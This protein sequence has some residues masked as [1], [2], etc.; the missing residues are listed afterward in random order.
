MASNFINP[1]YGKK[2]NGSLLFIIIAIIAVVGI[3]ICV[4]VINGSKPK[5]NAPEIKKDISVELGDEDYKNWNFYFSQID[6]KCYNE[7]N[8][9]VDYSKIDPTTVGTYDVDITIGSA[10]PKIVTV[11]LVDTK[12]PIL[13]L[14]S[15]LVIYADVTKEKNGISYKPEDFVEKCEDASGVCEVSFDVDTPEA[16]EEMSNHFEPG[17]YPISIVAHDKPTQKLPQGRQTMPQ[18]TKLVI[19]PDKTTCDPKNFTAKENISIDVGQDVPTDIKEYIV[20]KNDICWPDD[21]ITVDVSKVNNEVA[22]EYEAILTVKN[23]DPE[24]IKVKVNVIDTHSP[25]LT[26]KA[27]KLTTNSEKENNGISYTAEDFVEKCEVKEGLK[28]VVQFV[29]TDMDADGKQIDYGHY[30]NPG[31]YVIKLIASVFDDGETYKTEVSAKLTI[32]DGDVA[33]NCEFGTRKYDRTKYHLAYDVTEGGCA[34]DPQS[35]TSYSIR[36]KVDEVAN[37]EAQRIK[38][39]VQNKIENNGKTLY[40]NI[41]K[42]P[43]INETDTGLVG[44]SIRL[45]VSRDKVDG[46]NDSG[47]DKNLPSAN[48]GASAPVEEGE[49]EEPAGETIND[50]PKSTNTITNVCD[51]EIASGKEII[52]DYYLNTDHTRTY[53]MNPYAIPDEVKQQLES[54]NQSS[55]TTPPDDGDSV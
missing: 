24:E 32:I 31:E 29:T 36:S 37:L 2:K 41:C 26:T 47:T 13:V 53:S 34:I 33:L 12:V 8:V 17:T 52:V 27:L 30:S 5:C 7:Q 10:S 50:E 28:C 40:L 9:R 20:E 55:Q 42:N 3:F 19:M 45:V 23:L 48:S 6:E 14:K 22:G 49:N 44:Y 16:L 35:Y 15:E 25:K 46:I 38:V 43:V 4:L 39:Q 54:Y 18:N 1:G 11:E 51:A 21:K